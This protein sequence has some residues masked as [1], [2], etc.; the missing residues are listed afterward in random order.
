MWRGDPHA[1]DQWRALPLFCEEGRVARWTTMPR[2][3]R[4]GP[5]RLERK[6]YLLRDRTPV[7]VRAAAICNLLG[8]AKL[9]G[10]DSEV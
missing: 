6:N 8:S 10:M 9:N 3:A 5:W 4:S 1:L 7:E 2:S